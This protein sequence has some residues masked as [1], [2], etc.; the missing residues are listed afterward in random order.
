M[1]SWAWSSTRRAPA[2]WYSPPFSVSVSWREV[3]FSYSLGVP[4]ACR[5]RSVLVFKAEFWETVQESD[6]GSL[7]VGNLVLRVLAFLWPC[8]PGDLRLIWRIGSGGSTDIF[9]FIFD[10]S[11][12]GTYG[13]LQEVL[14]WQHFGFRLQASP[15][16]GIRMAVSSHSMSAGMPECLQNFSVRSVVCHSTTCVIE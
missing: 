7:P 1:A 5:W 4:R 16:L 9:I 13:F 3:E 12:R 14:S 15:K 10:L 6:L 11:W 2:R 8:V